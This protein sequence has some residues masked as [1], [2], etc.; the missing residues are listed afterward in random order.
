M[1]F[2]YILA[3][4]PHGTLYVGVTNNLFRRWLQH[5]TGEIPGF[6]RRYGVHRL[7]WFQEF[8]DIRD[9]IAFEKRVKRW[10]RDWKRSLIEQNNPHWIDLAPGLFGK[11]VQSVPDAP[12]R[13]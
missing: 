13:R 11:V 5:R 10:R 6:T 2:V 9:A 4:K 3:S 8:G 7:V 1:Y 12:R